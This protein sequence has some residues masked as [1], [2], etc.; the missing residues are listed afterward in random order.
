M[1]TWMMSTRGRGARWAAVAIG[2]LLVAAGPDSSASAEHS[3]LEQV[4]TGTT[5]GNG[6]FEAS[7][8]GAAADGSRVFFSTPE[9]LVSADTDTFVDVYERSGGQTTLVSTGPASGTNAS[10]AAFAGTSA[11]GSRVFVSTQ[12]RLVSADTDLF[13][14][15]YERSGG[16]TTLVSTGTTGGN[17]I[18]PA[19]YAGASA[20]GTRVF[21][22]TGESLVSADANTTT[23][24]YERSGGQTTLMSTGSVFPAVF[25]GASDDGGRIFYSTQARRVLADTDLERDIYERSG[26]QTTL[27]STAP[28]GGNGAFPALSAGVS[29]DGGRVF[30]RTVERLVSTDDDA[31]EDVYERAGGQTT[32]VSTG[33]TGGNGAFDAFFVGA[34]ADGTRVFFRTVESL[35]SADTD[36]VVDVYERAGGETTLVSTG[37]VGG[38]GAD[39]AFFDGVSADGT[40]V[41]LQTAE[42]LVSADTDTFL[43]VYERSGGQT[44]LVSTGPAGGN[45]TVDALFRG[46]SADGTRAS[47]S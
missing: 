20:D 30:F 2:S 7:L 31:M 43:D 23:D 25:V 29:D 46:S 19:S 42:S 12:E 22:M 5:G 24:V 40:R 9:P 38:N 18:F 17:G 8:A 3:S 41:F 47:S 28:F 33:V 32:L 10:P 26:G 44:T 21:F 1:N 36:T 11:D 15:V 16:Q 6:S 34:A 37:P 4:S 39:S 35:V 27:V 14:D 13:V 45:G